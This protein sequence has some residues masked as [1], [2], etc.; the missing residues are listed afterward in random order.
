MAM[1]LRLTDEQDQV[2]TALAEAEGVSKREAVV[3]A[4]L[5]RSAALDKDTEV[6]RLTRKA[7]AKYGPLLDRLGQ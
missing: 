6:R 5:E 3:R 2:L 1:S 4:I 7:E